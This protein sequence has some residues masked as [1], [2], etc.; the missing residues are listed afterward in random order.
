MIRPYIYNTLLFFA[1]FFTVF[2]IHVAPFSGLASPRNIV[3]ILLLLSYIKRNGLE[4][5]RVDKLWMISSITLFVYIFC[6]SV[7]NES[8]S[9]THSAFNSYFN[10]FIMIVILPYLFSNTSISI[11]QFAKMMVLAAMIQ[12]LI[13]FASFLF[14]FFRALLLKMQHFD[15]DFL[16]TRIVG[17][18]IA[19]AKGS[20]YL[21]CGFMMN[22]YLVV[23][24]EKKIR[25]FYSLL[26]IFFAIALV[27][28]TGFYMCLATIPLLIYSLMKADVDYLKKF[29]LIFKIIAAIMLLAGMC[30][31]F[32]RYV[33]VDL[34]AFE[35]TFRRLSELWTS[36][37][38]FEVLDEMNVPEL[39][40]NL[41]FWGNGWE[42]G[43]TDDGLRIWH[44]SGYVQRYFSLGLFPAILSYLFLF[45]YTISMIRIL[46]RA[47]QF[48][49]FYM[50]ISLFVIEYKE[51]FIYALSMPFVIIVSLMLEK[52]E[53]ICEKN[54]ILK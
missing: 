2:S 13:V 23:F 36:Q 41:F 54:C 14:P 33:G 3:I 21:F 5:F 18:G 52:K 32:Y 4:S 27:G 10:Y 39:T 43:I 31:F 15:D 11:K 53:I 47:K 25:Y 24:Y 50:L 9:P 28:R 38:T 34:E 6:I 48:F 42:K 49:W 17:L 44:D 29:I 8:F 16:I 35:Y 30:Y 46:R 45:L 20:V 26:F 1:V 19:G 37:R 12:S 22:L 51:P 40:P 7:F